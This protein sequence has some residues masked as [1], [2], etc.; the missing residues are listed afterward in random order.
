MVNLERHQLQ[1]NFAV[2]GG[3]VRSSTIG[4]SLILVPFIFLSVGFYFLGDQFVPDNS[5]IYVWVVL[6]VSFLFVGGIWLKRVATGTLARFVVTIDLESIEIKAYDRVAMQNL[7][8]SDFYPEQLQIS[9]VLVEI[10]GEDFRYPALVYADEQVDIVEESVPYP[11]RV[12]LG[13]DE[14][15]EIEKVLQLIQED[16]ALL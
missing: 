4:L 11:E 13:F 7:W 1:Y 14:R 6:A 12:I 2:N 8:V 15:E 5:R 10:N 16:I 3:D 9:E